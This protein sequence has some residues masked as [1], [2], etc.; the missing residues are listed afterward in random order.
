MIDKNSKTLV[1]ECENDD[2][3]RC[4]VVNFHGG[5]EYYL[6]KQL[7]IRDVRLVHA[8]ASSIGKY[9]GDIDNWMWPRHTG[10]YGFYRAYVNKDGQPADYSDDNVP[11]QPK[12][13]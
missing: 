9:G 3:Y 13:H 12:H 5:L 4:S 2:R 10:D 11:Y 7:T 6:F 8:P 1:A